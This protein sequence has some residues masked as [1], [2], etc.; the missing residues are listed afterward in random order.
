MR[1]DVDTAPWISRSHGDGILPGQNDN[2]TVTMYDFARHTW[3]MDKMKHQFIAASCYKYGRLRLSATKSAVKISL[4]IHGAPDE[5]R[6]RV[7]V[8]SPGPRQNTGVRN[9][10]FTGPEQ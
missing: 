6:L 2:Y 3:S 9:S 5:E 4:D 10:D 8:R 1:V 7:V